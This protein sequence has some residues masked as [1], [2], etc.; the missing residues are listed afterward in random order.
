[1]LLSVPEHRKGVM[2]LREKICV[3]NR[4]HTGMNY[5]AV[6]H[7]LSVNESTVHV[8]RGVFKQKH[9]KNKVIR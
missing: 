6:G 2:C 7:E 9:T 1:M 4:L 5:N 3:L 8:S